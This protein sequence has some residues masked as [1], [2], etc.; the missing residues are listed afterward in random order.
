[1]VTTRTDT[2]LQ[3]SFTGIKCP[4]YGVQ[5]SPYNYSKRCVYGS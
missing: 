1:M 5:L 3:P 2:R 4:V